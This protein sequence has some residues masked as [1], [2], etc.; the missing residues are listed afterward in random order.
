MKRGA[1]E[2]VHVSNYPSLKFS[3]IWQPLVVVGG[4]FVFALGQSGVVTS[5][6]AG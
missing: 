2:M 4:S 3:S 6:K 5:I 1:F